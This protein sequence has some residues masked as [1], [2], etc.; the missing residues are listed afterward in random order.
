MKLTL[1][2]A[3]LALAMFVSLKTVET[4]AHAASAYEQQIAQA[5]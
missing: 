2:L 3:G 5:R 4:V 1:F